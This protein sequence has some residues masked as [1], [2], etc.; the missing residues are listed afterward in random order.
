MFVLWSAN[1]TT[2]KMFGNCVF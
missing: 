2:Q 1:N